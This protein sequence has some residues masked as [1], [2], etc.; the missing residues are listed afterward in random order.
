M[1]QIRKFL[2][3]VFL[4]L[5]FGIPIVIS[6]RKTSRLE[7]SH[8]YT[9]GKVAGTHYNYYAHCIADYT[10]SYNGIEFHG[11]H[12]LDNPEIGGCYYVIFNPEDPKN[13]KLARV[14][15]VLVDQD[16][17]A[18]AGWVKLPLWPCPK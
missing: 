6:Q 17:V 10:F 14:C 18:R 8:R 11:D 13:N 16:T 4:I 9:I 1:A 3:Y 2:P 5:G 12:L 15:T 7:R